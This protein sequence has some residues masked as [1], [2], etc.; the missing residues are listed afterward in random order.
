MKFY[1]IP[2]AELLKFESEDIMR[3]S[4]EDTTATV[5]DAAENPG[6]VQEFAFD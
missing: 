3:T 5:K 2:E 6:D 1:E 4:P